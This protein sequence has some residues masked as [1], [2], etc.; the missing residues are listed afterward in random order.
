MDAYYEIIRVPIDETYGVVLYVVYCET[1][2]G[3]NYSCGSVY[4]AFNA[5]ESEDTAKAVV[6]AIKNGLIRIKKYH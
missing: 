6:N 1:Q 4:S 3:D 5:Y 2:R